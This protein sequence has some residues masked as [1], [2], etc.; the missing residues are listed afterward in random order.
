M[1]P[2]LLAMME[3]TS[4]LPRVLLL[5]IESFNISAWASRGFLSREAS[6]SKFSCMPVSAPMA[7]G[8]DDAKFPV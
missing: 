2:D 6:F 8:S 7:Q 4:C 1:R 5:D 3:C